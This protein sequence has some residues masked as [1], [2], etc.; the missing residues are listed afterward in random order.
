MNLPNTFSH[1]W[2]YPLIAALT[3]AFLITT[4]P[5]RTIAW[6]DSHETLESG[7]A[8]MAV[9]AKTPEQ[10]SAQQEVEAEAE[11][12]ADKQRRD[13]VDEAIAAV[14]M[15]HKALNLLS[16]EEPKTDE[17]I[18]ELEK[19]VG[20][21]EL[22]VAR[23]PELATIPVAV[24]KKIYNVIAST[25][26][27]EAMIQKATDALDDGHVQDARHILGGLASEYVVSTTRLPL[28]T[29]PDAIRDAVPLIDQGKIAEAKAQIEM[30]LNLLVVDE[31]V[32]PMPLMRAKAMLATAEDLTEKNDRK[33]SENEKLANLLD[34]AREELKFG[35]I[36][37]YYSIDE[38]E[39]LYEQ[40]KQIEGKTE[41]GQS[42]E[43][44]FN[45]IKSMV[46]D[47]F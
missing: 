3:M 28:A 25:E 22:L 17:V 30:A 37:G 15:T 4:A 11:M 34:A 2:S 9:E 14:Q 43:G 21:L 5:F 33:E 36:L 35:H 24:S 23:K 1:W 45:K 18:T 39:P 47:L 7:D 29:Y 32:Y 13:L 6:A 46:N 10:E 27:V 12:Q 40:I 19:V 42:G 16:E 8:T 31:T 20:K 44:Y 26:T 38:V 41:G